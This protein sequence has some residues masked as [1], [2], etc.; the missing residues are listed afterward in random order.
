VVTHTSQ[1]LIQWEHGKTGAH[2]CMDRMTNSVET[3]IDNHWRREWCGDAVRKKPSVQRNARKEIKKENRQYSL[4]NRNNRTL[5]LL[6]KL[7]LF[8]T[9]IF[10]VLSLSFFA[11]RGSFSLIHSSI[12]EFPLYSSSRFQP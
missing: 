1:R 4:L 12:I 3:T 8:D 7:F 11:S 2:A 6:L 9:E 5:T 10:P